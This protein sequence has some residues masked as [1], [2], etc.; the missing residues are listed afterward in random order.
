[1]FVT[2][3]DFNQRKHNLAGWVYLSCGMR[4]CVAPRP[5]WPEP[6]RAPLLAD[7]DVFTLAAWPA[8]SPPCPPRAPPRCPWLPRPRSVL[9]RPRSPPRPRPPRPRPRPDEGR[10]WPAMTGGV[11]VTG[12]VCT[13][14]TTA[15]GGSGVRP[16]A[17]AEY[18]LDGDGGGSS[19][20]K[21]ASST[22]AA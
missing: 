6:P 19:W 2:S 12:G 17:A 21:K 20:G 5:R 7:C 18:D 22:S 4:R 15:D 13:M 9:P 14:L 16:S 8:C 11:V 10:S 1:M 3:D